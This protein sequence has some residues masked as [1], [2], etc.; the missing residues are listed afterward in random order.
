M[1]DKSLADA[2]YDRV[3]AAFRSLG[4]EEVSKT[5][6]FFRISRVD[7]GTEIDFSEIRRVLADITSLHSWYDAWQRSADRFRALADEAETNGHR[8]TAGQHYL[9]TALLYHFAQLFTRPEDARRTEG[10]KKRVAYY[11]KACPYLDPVVVPVDI[12]FGKRRIPGYLRRA[13]GAEPTP[14][15]LMIPGA[16]S[17]KEELYNWGR[18]LVRRG[19]TTLAFDGPGQG[20]FS[21]RNGGVPMRLE[22]YHEAV[23]AAIDFAERRDDLDATRVAVWGQST[24]GQLALRAA[25]H[26]RRVKAVVSLGGGYDFRLEITPTTPADVWEEARELYG[27]SC[28][29]EVEAYVREHGSLGNLTGRVRCPVLLLHGGQDNIVSTEEVARI[30][31][32][33]AGPVTLKIY[34]DGNHSACNRNLELAPFMADWTS[35]VLSTAAMTRAAE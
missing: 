5:D 24:G 31:N 6:E 30:K 13:R 1:N 19:L 15:V 20:E 17:V 28:F 26:D 23:S 32:E 9:R 35:D 11:R 8:V 14:L 22:T 10:Q 12:P 18:E 29:A 25:A 2:F 33:V 27:L 16:N 34:E 21:E 3:D 7:I 4:A